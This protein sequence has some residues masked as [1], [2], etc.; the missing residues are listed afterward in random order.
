MNQ[1]LPASVICDEVLVS[2]RRKLIPSLILT[3]L[4]AVSCGRTAPRESLEALAP[5]VVEAGA[6]A[7]TGCMENGDCGEDSVCIDDRCVFFGQCLLD[8]HCPGQ[9]VCENN[10]CTGDPGSFGQPSLCEIN[11]DCAERHYC[12]DQYCRRGTECLAHAHCPPANACVFAVCVSAV[13]SD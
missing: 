11:A 12:V 8:S 6:D 7:S 9:S 10:E 1:R 3:A 13:A 4:F 5:L 2:M